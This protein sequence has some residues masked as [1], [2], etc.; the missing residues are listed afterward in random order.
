[1][2]SSSYFKSDDKLTNKSDYHAW[3][4][5]LDLTLEEQDVIDYLYGKINEPPSNASATTK[6]KYK[7][8][9]VKA[10]KISRDSIRKHLVGILFVST[11]LLIS[12]SWAHLRRCMISWLACSGLAMLIK[13]Y[14]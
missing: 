4:M 10:K 7:K 14:F 13:F 12:P 1:M 3:K 5:S 9:E 2:A 6:T 11:W 8:G